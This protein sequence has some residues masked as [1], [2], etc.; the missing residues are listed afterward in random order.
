ME[1]HD[2]DRVSILFGLLLAASGLALLAG[3]PARG[4]VWLGW[5]AP[6]IAIGLG[7]LVVLAVRPRRIE[8]DDEPPTGREDWPAPG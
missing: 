8:L 4:T 3:D 2:V 6:A 1:R 5:V 7:L